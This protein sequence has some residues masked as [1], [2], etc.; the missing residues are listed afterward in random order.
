MEMAEKRPTTKSGLKTIKGL[1]SGQI[2]TLGH[3]LLEKIG[4]ALSLP[5]KSLPVY[6][7]KRRPSFGPEVSKRM[8]AFK[9]WR[10]QRALELDLDQ[11]LVCNNAQILSLSLADPKKPGDLRGVGEIKDWQRKAFGDEICALL[12]ALV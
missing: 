5:D 9:K 10:S 12:K 8:K 7:F 6:P 4:E 3:S 2:R 11:A 1:S